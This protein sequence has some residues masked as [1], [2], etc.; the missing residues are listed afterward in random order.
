MI[1]LSIFGSENANI[2]RNLK[3]NR[4]PAFNASLSPTVCVKDYEYRAG[5]S[6]ET[7]HGQMKFFG[8]QRRVDIVD[9]LRA[10]EENKMKIYGKDFIGRAKPEQ[11]D[12]S[13][14]EDADDGAWKNPRKTPEGLS[15]RG[16]QDLLKEFEELDLRSIG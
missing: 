8:D 12:D 5:E 16:H 15:E 2:G 3:Q 4:T 14:W 6:E 10:T 9:G 13:T 7:V 1:C 11:S